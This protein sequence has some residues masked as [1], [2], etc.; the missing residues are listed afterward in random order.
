MYAGRPIETGNVED[1]FYDPR[2]PY[3]LGLLGAT[4][5]IEAPQGRLATI[6]GL[7]PSLEHL[8]PGCA[9]H[10]RCSFRFAP[11]FGERPLLLPVGN[12]H[13]K[14]CFYQGALKPAVPA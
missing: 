5:D 11:C 1:L 13:A 9:F 8:P 12:D 2:H 7:P 4:P 10:P 14:A 3:T 6:P